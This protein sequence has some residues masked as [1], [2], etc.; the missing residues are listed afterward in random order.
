MRGRR[1]RTPMRSRA[2]FF[3]LVLVLAAGGC[4]GGGDPA[5]VTPTLT[6]SPALP[7]APTPSP[8][9][10]ATPEPTVPSGTPVPPPPR[11]VYNRSFDF[12]T[13]GDA[14]GQA[15]K[16]ESSE[17]VGEEHT[18]IVVN[19]TLERSSAAPTPLPVSGTISSPKVRVLDPEGQEIFVES[20]EGAARVESFP[21]K[22]GAY[23]IR[24]EGAGT[25]R[26]IVVLTATT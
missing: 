20:R 23:A 6:P 15:P 8:T 5:Q 26:A 18:L 14:T 21:A 22:V 9:P 3:A 2:L 1:V 10:P 19:V 16:A 24:Y 13:E 4:L 7:P 12:S 25:L 17:S 11:E